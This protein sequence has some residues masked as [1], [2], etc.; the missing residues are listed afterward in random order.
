MPNASET[1]EGSPKD[2]SELD[3][4]EESSTQKDVGD[5]TT[6]IQASIEILP[7]TS[8]LLDTQVPDKQREEV[9]PSEQNKEV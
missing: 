7:D 3:E 8:I 5:A 6:S 2:N 1:Q 4:S 9:G